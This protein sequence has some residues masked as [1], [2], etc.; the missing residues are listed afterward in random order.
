MKS[1]CPFDGKYSKNYLNSAALF[2][3]KI[4]QLMAFNLT[5]IV[6]EI[7]HGDI[8]IVERYFGEVHKGKRGRGVAVEVVVFSM[9]KSHSRVYAIVLGNINSKTLMN[10]IVLKIKPDSVVYSDAYHN[11]DVLVVSDSKFRTAL[12]MVVVE[13]R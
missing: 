5:K 13:A 9:L 1:D 6:R 11:Y 8:G 4:R 3:R 10:E 2:Y 12:S 7:F